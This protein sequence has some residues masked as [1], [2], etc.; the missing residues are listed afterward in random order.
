MRSRTI[1]QEYGLQYGINR[2]VNL[3]LMLPVVRMDLDENVAGSIQSARV[4][5]AGDAML[6]AKYRFHL[7][8][9]TGFQTSQTLVAGWKIPTGSDGRIGPDGTRLPPGGQPGSGRHGIEIGYAYDRERLVDTVWAS[10]FFH[11]E[12][13][14]G[15]RAGDL[16]LL[17]AAYGRW[18][19]RP[20]VA[21]DLGVMLAFGVHAE[22]AASDRLEGDLSAGNDHRVAGFQMTPIVTRGRNQYRAGVF[23]PV[24]KRGDPAETDFGYEL[25]LGWETFF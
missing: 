10:G 1:E 7:R 21:E 9:E 18:I 4:S 16:G 23:V 2:F 14:G 12:L 24:V 17:D 15:F 8:Q 22:M 20:N 6:E 5:G 11:H 19:V 3:R 13:G 25:R